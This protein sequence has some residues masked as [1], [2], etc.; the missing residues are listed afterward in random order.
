MN[1]I[2]EINS[3]QQRNALIMEDLSNNMIDVRVAIIQ[4]EGLFILFLKG[5]ILYQ[6]EKYD[7]SP[8][9]AENTKI[10]RQ[11]ADGHLNAQEAAVQSN[12]I[13][14]DYIN[15]LRSPGAPKLNTANFRSGLPE[16]LK[17]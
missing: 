17:Q 13:W 2:K 14:V 8:Q 5:K 4:S 11:L 9:E 1:L 16:F 6:N 12:S 15:T 3:L 10:I 7:F